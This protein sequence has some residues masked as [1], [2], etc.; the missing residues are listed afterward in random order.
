MVPLGISSP[1]AVHTYSVDLPYSSVVVDVI[2]FFLFCIDL[3]IVFFYV[4][5]EISRVQVFLK[6]KNVI[7]FN[8]NN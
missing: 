7:L 2:L 5:C 6:S 3:L 4:D 8:N 1:S